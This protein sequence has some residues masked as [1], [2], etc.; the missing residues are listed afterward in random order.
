MDN[1]QYSIP[2]LVSTS[3]RLEW[4][5]TRLSS[6]SKSGLDEALSDAEADY[7]GIRELQDT[8]AK[9]EGTISGLTRRTMPTIGNNSIRNSFDAFANSIGDREGETARQLADA[10]AK[11]AEYARLERS[12]SDL[13]VLIKDRKE[14]IKRLEGGV[15][16]GFTRIGGYNL[17]T[18]PCMSF[19]C[20][21][22]RANSVTSNAARDRVAETFRE[23][24]IDCGKQIDQY[25]E[26]NEVVQ[27]ATREVQFTYS[28]GDFAPVVGTVI[29]RAIDDIRYMSTGG[30]VHEIAVDAAA[31]CLFVPFQPDVVRDM[32]TKRARHS[33]GGL[34]TYII[35]VDIEAG[36]AESVIRIMKADSAKFIK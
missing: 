5:R 20:L 29:Y 35:P 26:Q 31:R 17:D 23:L 10:K 36:K 24:R 14:Q 28:G 21:C 32:I 12:I 11:V 6:L 9:L 3:A 1:K 2:T 34:E 18:K 7:S 15:F 33:G 30:L 4:T 16:S 25:L 13:E 27:Y 8:L 22:L 19:I